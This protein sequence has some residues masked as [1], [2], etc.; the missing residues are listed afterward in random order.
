MI[1]ISGNAGAPGVTLSYFDGS[2]QTVTSDGSGAYYIPVPSGWSGTVTP[3]RPSYAFFPTS[4]TYTNVTANL[5][6]QDYTATTS[7][8]IPGLID[9]LSITNLTNTATVLVEDYGPRRHNVY[10][11]FIGDSCQVSATVYPNS[12]IEMSSN[13]VRSLF[14]AMGYPEGSITMENVPDGSGGSYGHN[15]YVTKIGT[16]YPNTFIEF[17]GHLDT[18]PGTPGGNDNAS[19]SV[20]VIELARVLKDYPNRYSMRFA[21]WTSE[22]LGTGA[23]GALSHVQQALARSEQIKAGL[24]INSVGWPDP[25]DPTGLMN[26]IWY[27]N[28]E[29]QRIANLFNQV[30]TDYGISIGFRSNAATTTSDERAYWNLG[31]TAVTSVGGWSTYRPNYHGCGD[32]VANIDFTNTL[33]TAQENLAVG[34]RLDGELSHPR[35]LW[36]YPLKAYL[37]I[38][39]PPQRQPLRCLIA[40]AIH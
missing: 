14:L 35:S 21:V 19:G 11:P 40:L 31:Q 15:V 28:A 33:R 30:R 37:P 17:G 4:R 36:R 6:A 9:Q 29:S 34:L 38:A 13:Y 1:T 12:T 8:P 3:S 32:T 5:T 18:Q 24:N 27:N 2:N 20:A 39:P 26:E 16:T 7:D 23:S 10:S 22:E 25:S